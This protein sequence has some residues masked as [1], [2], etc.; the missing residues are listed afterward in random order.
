MISK[1]IES[2]TNKVRSIFVDHYTSA[3]S[4][5]IQLTIKSDT[6]SLAGHY[7]FL[8]YLLEQRTLVV[9]GPR[10]TGKTKLLKKLFKDHKNKALYITYNH[11]TQK[12][13]ASS[14]GTQCDID[15]IQR[16]DRPIRGLNHHYNIIIFDECYNRENF[17]KV[18]SSLELW[19]NPNYNLT[20]IALQSPA[21]L[22]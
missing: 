13:I 4:D 8:H 16:F 6:R 1:L 9:A 7:N 12:E 14:L 5:L 3:L 15:P 19:K 18:Y 20:I 11:A 2:Y 22:K 21:M 10:Q 17:E